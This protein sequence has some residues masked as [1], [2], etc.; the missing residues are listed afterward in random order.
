MSQRSQHFLLHILIRLSLFTVIKDGTNSHPK[1]HASVFS[2]GICFT[3]V[4][5]VA[6]G[7]PLAKV[8]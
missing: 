4:M 3:R 6:P 5:I 7:S 8:R 2:Y 1:G